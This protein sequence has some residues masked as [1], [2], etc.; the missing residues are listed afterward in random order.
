MTEDRNNE[1]VDQ[2]KVS[3]V[4]IRERKKIERNEQN[5]RGLWDHIKCIN[6]HVIRFPEKEKIEMRQE[7][8]LKNN[9]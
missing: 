4:K 3:S 5:F 6:I 9:C 8:N 7:K 2:Q 1:L